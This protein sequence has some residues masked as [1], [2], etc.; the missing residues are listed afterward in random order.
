MSRHEHWPGKCLCSVVMRYQA[1]FILAVFSLIGCVST[2]PQRVAKAASA[3]EPHNIMKLP[4]PQGFTRVALLPMVANANLGSPDSLRGINLAITE[5]LGKAKRFEIIEIGPDQLRGWGMSPS[6]DTLGPWSDKLRQN[7]KTEQIDGVMV[8][9]IT[10]LKG[11]E[12]IS[13]GIKSRIVGIADGKTYWACDEVFD[14]AMP[15]VYAGA[16]RFEAGTLQ[17]TVRGSKLVA[18]P[19]IELSPSKFAKYAAY[20]LFQTLPGATID[21][22]KSTESGRHQR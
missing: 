11:Y 2:H 19:T 6:I 3:Y 21:E 18:A 10:Q 14:A 4:L 17:E 12:P 5:E 16:K 13:I 15:Q 1:L 20:S 8:I 22:P 9:E 7:L